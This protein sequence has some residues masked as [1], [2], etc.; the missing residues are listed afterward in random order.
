M[1]RTFAI[2]QIAASFVLLAGAALLV[3]S[4]LVLRA[5]DPGFDT[6]VLAVNLPI[7]SFGKSRSRFAGFYREVERRIEALPGVKDVAVGSTVPWRDGNAA[8]ADFQF[9]VEGQRIQNGDENRRANFRSAS[10][11]FFRTAD[12][13]IVAGR[14]FNEGDRLGAE[15]VVI[16]SAA[17]AEQLLP[18]QDPIGRRLTWT[19]PR[20][21]FVGISNEPRRIVGV[22]ADVE[23]ETVAPS[24]QLSVYH[25][26]EQELSGGRLFVSAGTDPYALVP[27]IT[28]IVRE[29]AADQPVER[30]STLE[31]VRA[32][33]LAPD[34]LNAIVGGRI[35]GGRARHRAGGCR[36]RA[37]VL[38]QQ[39]HPRVRHPAR[40][41]LAAGSDSGGRAPRGRGHGPHRRRRGR[42]RGIRDPPNRQRLHSRSGNGQSVAASP[43]GHRAAPGGGRRRPD[44]GRPRREGG[45]HPGASRGHERTTIN[46][47]SA[48][49]AERDLLN[50]PSAR[51]LGL[52]A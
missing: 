37:C 46:A 43:C 38:R 32:E 30:A 3:R 29:L 15:R 51:Q 45:R 49:T 19:D 10:P 44:P 52:L 35:R 9:S 2:T 17:L 27:T 8:G 42:R 5:T 23:D 6:R 40:G 12:I 25:P 16:V 48:E 18:G 33:V 14:D 22:V 11:G 1:L 21:K 31:D 47:E 50:G 36:R 7:M 4:L 28:R 24:R 20:T 41:R 26:F 39:P 34:R 13:P